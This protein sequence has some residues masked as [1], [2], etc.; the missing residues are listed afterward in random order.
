MRPYFA[1][2][3]AGGRTFLFTSRDSGAV[4]VYWVD[5]GAVAALRQVLGTRR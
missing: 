4:R 1:A 2:L 3:S 5:A